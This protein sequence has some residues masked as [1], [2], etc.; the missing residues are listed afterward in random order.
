MKGNDAISTCARIPHVGAASSRSPPSWWRLPPVLP[1]RRP[2]IRT[3]AAHEPARAGPPVVRRLPRRH[4]QP[5]RP[6]AGHGA[7]RSRHHGPVLHQRTS[8]NPCQPSWDGV[9]TLDQAAAT[10]GVDSQIRPFREAGNDIA[11]S[12]GGQLGTELAAACTDVDALVR[13]YSAVITKYGLD[14]WT[15]TSKAP[16]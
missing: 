5:G 8:E 12:F 11:V 9:H 4:P 13:A 2:T 7:P 6:A 16:G 3:G 10:L 15:S 14:V 1:H